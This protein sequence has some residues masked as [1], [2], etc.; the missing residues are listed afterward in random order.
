ML[1]LYP[2]GIKHAIH[3]CL[4][5]KKKNHNSTNKKIKSALCKPLADI[6]KIFLLSSSIVAVILTLLSS[7]ESGGEWKKRAAALPNSSGLLHILALLQVSD[8]GI[9]SRANVAYLYIRCVGCRKKKTLLSDA[10]TFVHLNLIQ[11]LSLRLDLNTTA[12][13]THCNLQ[14]Q[15]FAGDTSVW[16]QH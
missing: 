2:D 4:D 15:G 8:L 12:K 16:F 14:S 7:A 10:L 5:K 13:Q 9:C 6:K 1:H 11:L 3:L